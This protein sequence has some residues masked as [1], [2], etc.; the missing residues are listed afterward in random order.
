M[1]RYE[2]HP[3]VKGWPPA[4]FTDA[5]RVVI[6]RAE[7]RHAAFGLGIQRCIGSHLARMETAVA[8]EQWLAKIPEFSLAPD[9]N[10]TWSPGAVRGPRQLPLILG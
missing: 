1:T 2:H 7:N 4:V 5:E 8:L 10:V 6:D 9:A 3:L